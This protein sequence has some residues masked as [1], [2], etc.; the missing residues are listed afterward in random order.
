MITAILR[1]TLTPSTVSVGRPRGQGCCGITWGLFCDDTVSVWHK[2][3][4]QLLDH[5]ACCPCQNS[6]DDQAVTQT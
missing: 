3:E 1:D 2:L 4:P 6:K 5:E